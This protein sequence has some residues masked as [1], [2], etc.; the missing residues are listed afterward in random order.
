MVSATLVQLFAISHNIRGATSY[1]VI[2]QALAFLKLAAET[3]SPAAEGKWRKASVK[4]S[5]KGSKIVEWTLMRSVEKQTCRV[6]HCSRKPRS[7]QLSA[8]LHLR[9]QSLKSD[10]RAL[11]V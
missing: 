9:T 3:A 11:V 7:A 10:L 1:C 4:A 8:D 6:E 2:K 5:L